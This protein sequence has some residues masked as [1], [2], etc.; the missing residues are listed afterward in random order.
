MCIVLTITNK[1]LKIRI[2]RKL[3][4]TLK[5]EIISDLENVTGG[6]NPNRTVTIP[7]TCCIVEE[8]KHFHSC[9]T[10][11]NT[12]TCHTKIYC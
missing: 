5:K 7:G 9:E 1:Q 12:D 8:T 3:K 11:C 6:I 4:L 10:D 2:M